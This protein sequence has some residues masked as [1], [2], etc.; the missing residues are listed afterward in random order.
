[1]GGMVGNNAHG[2]IVDDEPLITILLG[3]Q[4]IVSRAVSQRVETDLQRRERERL[5]AF[6]TASA[7]VYEV[8]AEN[9]TLEGAFGEGEITDIQRH[10][11]YQW[12]EIVAQWEAEANAPPQTSNANNRTHVSAPASNWIDWDSD[13]NPSTAQVSTSTL[14]N[15]LGNG[16]SGVISSAV[17]PDFIPTWIEPVG[18]AVQPIVNWVTDFS[19]QA[20]VVAGASGGLNNNPYI[21]HALHIIGTITLSTPGRRR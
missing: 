12:L 1:M 6:L 11:F 7:Y 3:P 16:L 8:G 10:E 14:V 19:L 21:N 17:I 5:E 4:L 9:A 20:A 15:Q 13:T 18:N 2:A